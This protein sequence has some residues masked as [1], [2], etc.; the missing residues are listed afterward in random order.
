MKLQLQRSSTSSRQ[1][2]LP[3]LQIKL[4]NGSPQVEGMGVWYSYWRDPYHLLLT[5]PWVGFLALIAF[6]YVTINALFAVVYL[7]GGDCVANAQPRSFLDKFFFSVQTLATIGYGFMYPKTLYANSVV[8]IEVMVGIIG[9]AVLTGLSFARFSRS[10]ARVIFSQVAVITTHEGL[11]SLIFRAANQRRNQILEAQMRV[12]LMRDEVTAE[13]QYIR[14]ICDL[15]LRRSQSPGFVLTWSAIHPIDAESPL[16]GI[17]AEDL[18]HMN[19]SVV[20]SLSGLDET[21]AQMVH[22]RHT[23][24]VHE[25]LWNHRFVDVIYQASNGKRY[26]DYNF[27]HDVV[28]V[29]LNG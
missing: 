29:V 27:F 26:I 6:A 19:V 12:Y 10:T 18:V 4:Q 20:I 16:Y 8:T 13:G 23:Y 25:I 2:R 28:P 24:G 9:I 5:I 1:R 15:K 3:R 11:P 21:I 17:S 7:V 22:A 14:R